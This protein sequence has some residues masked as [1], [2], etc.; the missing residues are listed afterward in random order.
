LNDQ[1]TFSITTKIYDKHL[2]LKTNQ[3]NVR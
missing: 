1:L 2:V 3:T